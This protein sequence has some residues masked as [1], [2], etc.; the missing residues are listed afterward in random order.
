MAARV[1]ATAGD[2]SS[3]V[4]RIAYWSALGLPEHKASRIMDIGS[5]A[6]VSDDVSLG[7]ASSAQDPRMVMVESYISMPSRVVLRIGE[8]VQ[9]RQ[10]DEGI[11]YEQCP[12]DLLCLEESVEFT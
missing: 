5:T 8:T 10:I 1:M 2:A 6:M 12:G 9:R 11:R 7:P 4:E 3:T